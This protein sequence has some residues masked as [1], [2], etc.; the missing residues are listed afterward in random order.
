MLPNPNLYGPAEK[1]PL[2]AASET[3]EQKA[4]GENVW[5]KNLLILI[6]QL[7]ILQFKVKII[8]KH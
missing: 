6:K 8:L 7:K 4:R 5:R 2:M 1:T 3:E